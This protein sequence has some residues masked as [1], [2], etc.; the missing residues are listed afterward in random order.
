M[1]TRVILIA[2][3][4]ISAF[5]AICFAHSDCEKG[6]KFW[7]PPYYDADG[8]FVPGRFWPC[9]TPDKP[10]WIPPR[11]DREGKFVPGYFWPPKE[12]EK[13]KKRKK[14]GGD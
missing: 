14:K 12:C 10:I 2:V 8:K 9:G 7:V 11:Y 13:S 4:S 6:D 5:A 3:V 1:K